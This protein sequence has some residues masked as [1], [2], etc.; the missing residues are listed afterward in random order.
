MIWNTSNSDCTSEA[1]SKKLI[2]IIEK[3]LNYRKTSRAQRSRRAVTPV[4]DSVMI[5]VIIH[6]FKPIDCTAPRVTLDVNCGLWMMT[7]PWRFIVWNKCTIWWGTL[8]VGGLS[9][10]RETFVPSVQ[11]CYEPN[12]MLYRKVCFKKKDFSVQR[13]S[14]WCYLLRWELES[15]PFIWPNRMVSPSMDRMQLFNN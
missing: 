8:V 2:L 7:C 15:K 3:A 12:T 11:F 10:G 4:Y 5:H 6:L 9:G 14:P 13:F 1:L